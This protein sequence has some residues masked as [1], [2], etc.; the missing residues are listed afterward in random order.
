MLA[1][2]YVRDEFNSYEAARCR[3]PL[4]NATHTSSYRQL[5]IK[6]VHM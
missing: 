1:S 4:E 5:C 3:K 6:F 2:F